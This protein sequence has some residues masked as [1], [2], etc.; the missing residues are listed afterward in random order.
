MLANV[1]FFVIPSVG[2]MAPPG[3]N[4]KALIRLRTVRVLPGCFRFFFDCRCIQHRAVFFDMIMCGHQG[5]WWSASLRHFCAHRRRWAA[6]LWLSSFFTIS[7][8]END[9]EHMKNP[10]ASVDCPHDDWNQNRNHIII[11]INNKVYLMDW[12]IGQTTGNNFFFIYFVELP[13]RKFSFLFISFFQIIIHIWNHS[14]TSS[15]ANERNWPNSRSSWG[16]DYR[17]YMVGYSLLFSSWT[18]RRWDRVCQPNRKIRRKKENG[19]QWTL[20]TRSLH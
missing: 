14:Y 3:I 2:G 9:D 7:R 4:Y 12:I 18:F 8:E 17:G 15:D 20:Y 5:R 16:V 1:Y 19:V 13:T 10:S 11:R 6:L